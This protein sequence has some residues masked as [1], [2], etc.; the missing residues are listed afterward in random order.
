MN[1]EISVK[2]EWINNRLLELIDDFDKKKTYNRKKAFYSYLVVTILGATITV[3]LGLNISYLEYVFRGIALCLGAIIT[4]YS[5]Y[6]SFFNFKGLWLKYNDTK[7][8][9]YS[10]KDDLN[11]FLA[12]NENINSEELNKF[13]K[14]LDNILSEINEEWTTLKTTI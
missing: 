11:Y 10:I 5:A 2:V 14:R 1:P 3:L 12:G 8:K 6:N 7:N 4:I 13:K 9:L